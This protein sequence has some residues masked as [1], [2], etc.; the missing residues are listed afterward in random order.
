MTNLKQ[1]PIIDKDALQKRIDELSNQLA[2]SE[3]S[4]SSLQNE[5]NTLRRT[6]LDQQKRI[7]ELEKSPASSKGPSIVSTLPKD[8]TIEIDI[9]NRKQQ[10]LILERSSVLAYKNLTDELEKKLN[11]ANSRISKLTKDFETI[12]QKT[13]GSFSPEE[14][15][16]Y[17]SKSIDQ[18]NSSLNKASTGVNYVI[19]GMDVEMKTLLAQKNGNMIFAM[20]NIASEGS[21][22]ISTIKF[23]IKPIPKE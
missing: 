15:A 10:E 19:N 18:F 8:E 21:E 2:S 6:N 1:P 3:A 23:S 17:L 11:E 12:S 9:L 4:K 14:M 5:I 7:A 20:P 16:G 13:Q 22:A